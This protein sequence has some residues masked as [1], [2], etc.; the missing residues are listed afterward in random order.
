MKI[1]SIIVPLLINISQL[2]GVWLEWHAGVSGNF[3]SATSSKVSFFDNNKVSQN[4]EILIGFSADGSS[5]ASRTFDMNLLMSME[6][7]YSIE[8]DVIKINWDPQSLS[9]TSGPKSTEGYEREIK[10]YIKALEKKE[11]MQMKSTAEWRVLDISETDMHIEKTI[12]ES[13][14]VFHFVKEQH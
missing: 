5:A 3:E 11:S 1:L 13:V 12:G 10:F 2:S 7:V 9:I 8:N 6:G 4:S 14:N